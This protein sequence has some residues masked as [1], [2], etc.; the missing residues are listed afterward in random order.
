MF[1]FARA[2]L[3]SVPVALLA[4]GTDSATTEVPDI[5]T[6]TF[7]GSLGVNLAAST[8]TANGLYYRDV[9]LGT[10]AVV[11]VGQQIGV[12]YTL[13]L[14]NGTQVESNANGT[15]YP[16]RIGTGAVIPG[17]DQ[18]IPGMKV[19]GVRQLIIPPALAY[20]VAGS[21]PAI[22]SNAILVFQVQVV[23]AQ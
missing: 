8:K 15:P 22:G 16:V 9:T 23:S 12:T 17:W 21:P 18:G 14:P 4:C 7:A 3:L 11:A 2:L 5:E 10:G 19:G 1:R 13:W 20:G 6:T